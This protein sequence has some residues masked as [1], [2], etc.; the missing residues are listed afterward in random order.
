MN[1]I[2]SCPPSLTSAF[3]QN[4]TDRISK[5]ENVT[6]SCLLSNDLR[7]LHQTVTTEKQL[8]TLNSLPQVWNHLVRR[9]S[10]TTPKAHSA[11]ERPSSE[12]EEQK[13]KAII[14]L[15]LLQDHPGLEMN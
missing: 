15:Q 13:Y 12:S 5:A 9:V 3:T 7:L 6:P 10:P 1:E 11:Q 2:Y 14:W 4:L 8:P